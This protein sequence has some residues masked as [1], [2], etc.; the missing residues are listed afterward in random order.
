MKSHIKAG[1]E[2]R[3]QQISQCQAQFFSLSELRL[4]QCCAKL[5]NWRKIRDNSAQGVS[6]DNDQR[7]SS[8]VRQRIEALYK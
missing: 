4:L 6:S 8:D 3:L 5:R 7:Q 1:S 2:V